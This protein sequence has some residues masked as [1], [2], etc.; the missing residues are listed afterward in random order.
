MIYMDHAATTPLSREV[1]EAM[2]PWLKEGFGNASALYP[3]G[4]KSAAAIDR[5][6]EQC[7]AVI[8]AETG[9]VY[10]TSGGS[11]SDNWALIKTAEKCL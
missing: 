8:G 7:A 11:E 2:L 9:E 6:R 4:L 1:L 10:F 3:L 5:A